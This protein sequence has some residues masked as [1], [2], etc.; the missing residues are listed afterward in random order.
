[1][2]RYRLAFICRP[3]VVAL[4][5]AIALFLLAFFRPATNPKIARRRADLFLL[6]GELEVAFAQLHS[7]PGAVRS[8]ELR[9]DVPLQARMWCIRGSRSSG[10]PGGARE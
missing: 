5:R 10:V 4:D 2:S 6:A 7:V 8:G 9:C 1:M 3:L